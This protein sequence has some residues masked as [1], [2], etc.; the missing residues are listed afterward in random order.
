MPAPC[1]V[2]ARITYAALSVG[3][4]IL[5]GAD[6]FGRR[7]PALCRPFTTETAANI[8]SDRP[9]PQG[10]EE[11]VAA[12][13]STYEEA[14][15]AELSHLEAAALCIQ[16]R[17]RSLRQRRSYLAT[18]AAVKT[19][20]RRARAAAT[21]R[22]AVAATRAATCI[23]AHFR[24][25]LAAASHVP[26]RSG[27]APGR[28]SPCARVAS[29]APCGGRPRCQRRPGRSRCGAAAAAYPEQGQGATP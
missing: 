7:E 3:S 14:A 26:C 29:S 16:A 23:Q 19:L 8:S 17:Y 4:R 25:G 5:T 27:S 1:G 20:H 2:L 24:G 6:L 12:G 28:A 10:A 22:R 21:W 13:H 11:K 9:R 18:L 15:T